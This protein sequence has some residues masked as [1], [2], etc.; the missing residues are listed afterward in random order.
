MSTLVVKRDR[1]LLLR[2]WDVS[3]ETMYVLGYDTTI[4]HVQDI[5][6]YLTLNDV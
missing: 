2:Y 5:I 4:R 3:I 6:I 1:L